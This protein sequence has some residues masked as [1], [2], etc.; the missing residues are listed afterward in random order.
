MPRTRR[1]AAAKP[2]PIVEDEVFEDLDDEGTEELDDLDDLEVEEE[3]PAP[4]AK[5]GRKATPKTAPTEKAEPVQKGSGFDSTWLAEHVSNATGKTYDAR[6]IRMLLRKAAKDG[7]LAREVGVDRI[8]YDFPK[9]ANDPVVK[10]IVKMA[11][12]GAVEKANKE[13]VEN[14]K[15]ARAAKPAPVE[16][17]EDED[18]LEEAPAPKRTRKATTTKAAAPAKAAPATRRRRAAA[19]DE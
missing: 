5:K 13:G 4:A 3:A 17:D 1:T 18:E 11:Q 7:V 8:R 19:S 12:S 10:S 15:K 6:S 2:E 9:G 16:V 14:A